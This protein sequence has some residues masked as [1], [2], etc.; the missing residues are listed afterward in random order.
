MLLPG[1]VPLVLLVPLVPFAGLVPLVVPLLVPL[2]G[3]VPLVV[4]LVPLVGL[5]PLV[6][7]LDELPTGRVATPST[8]HWQPV[9]F[10]LA[11]ALVALKV[12]HAH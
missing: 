2:V 3:L 5:V 4:P 12:G 7:L 6:A 8:Q 1:L 11:V 10:L 9:K